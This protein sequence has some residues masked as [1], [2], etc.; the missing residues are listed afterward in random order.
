M[1]GMKELLGRQDAIEK[2][3]EK[4]VAINE[5]LLKKDAVGVH[6]ATPLHGI[7]GIFSGAGIENPVVSAYIRPAGLVGFLRRIPTVNEDPRFSA[8]TG[9]TS[10]D[11][12]LPTTSCEDAQ[13]GYMKSCEL[14]ARFG[15]N[16]MDTKEIEM[17]KTML[18]ANRGDRTDLVLLGEL[19]GLSGASP[20][21]IDDS[22]VLEVVTK[23]EMITCAINVERQIMSD[24]WTGLVA[25]GSFPGLD[26][27]IATGQLDARTGGACPALDSDVKDFNYNDVCGAGFDI[28][29][30]VSMMAWY[31]LHNA[32]R[33]GLDPVDWAIVMRPELWF[34][35]SACWPCSYLS[36][37]CNNSDGTKILTV[38]DSTNVDMR[39]AMRNGMYIDINGRRYRV[40]LDDGIY[41]ANNINNAN[42]AAAQYASSLYFVP[43]TAR[44]LP[45][46]YM[47]YLD[48]RQASADVSLL[49]GKEN[50]WWTDNG[51][52]SWS[53]TD[54]KWCYQLHL[55]TEPRVVLRT[56]QL[57]GKV[58]SI[59]YSPLQHLRSYD[60]DS[61]Y[62]FDGGVSLAPAGKRYSV[63]MAQGGPGA[64]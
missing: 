2:L 49:Q 39:D 21:S 5:N 7:T 45:V 54:K 15:L 16:R 24:F 47:E 13:S 25:A 64:A 59:G 35:L 10:P 58:Q 3:L 63:W 33:S 38:N 46:T 20:D 1:D 34:E 4:Q 43:F 14:T 17:D 18:R 29:E 56:P 11:G 41:E 6:A 19:F 40:I 53:I 57:A 22:N 52:F 55:K 37:R 51:M 42:L 32:D 31:L 26:T 50:F 44:G 62:A 28:V 61:P 8:I 23:A 48:Y 27:Q 36:N 60:P 9:F 12:T 30:Y